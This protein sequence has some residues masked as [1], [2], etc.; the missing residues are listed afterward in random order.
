MTPRRSRAD[1]SLAAVVAA[2]AARD[3][4]NPDL[5]ELELDDSYYEEIGMTR[6]EAMQ[7]QQEVRKHGLKPMQASGLGSCL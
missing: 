5:D 7:Q 2:A 1:G 4:D 6:E 3:R